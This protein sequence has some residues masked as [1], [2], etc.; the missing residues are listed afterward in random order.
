MGYKS[1]L[2]SV[3]AAGRHYERE[4]IR[5]EREIQKMIDQQEKLQQLERDALA[6]K[7][8]ENYIKRMTTLHNDCGESYNWH[9]ISKKNPKEP[10][11]KSIHEDEAKIKLDSYNPNFLEKLFKLDIKKTAKLRNNIESAKGKDEK[12]YAADLAE[13]REELELIQFSKR[14]LAED[15]GAY[16]EVVENIEPFKEISDIGSKVEVSFITSKKARGVVYVQDEK[17]IPK[18]TKSLLKSG[19]LT[20]KDTPIS[21][22][23]EIYQDY[24]CSAVLRVGRELF[25]IL[26]LEEVIVTAKGN[27]L[28]TATGRMEEVSLLSA[29]L[30]L[31]TINTLDFNNIDPSDSMRNFKHNMG[32]KKSQGMFPVVELE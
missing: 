29:L 15:L 27:V 25:A 18:Q 2:R 30:V 4:S 32:F 22:Y 20:I 1:F 19:K 24:V 9:T 10:E 12:D 23:N 6:V 16:S 26:P 11:K 13:Y 21:K 7:E 28:N 5:H 8:Y 31:E 3:R 14:I 17:V